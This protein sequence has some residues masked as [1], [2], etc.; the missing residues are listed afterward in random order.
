MWVKYLPDGQ[1]R[2]NLDYLDEYLW[3]DD[4]EAFLK[5][6]IYKAIRAD[7]DVFFAHHNDTTRTWYEPSLD[8]WRSKGDRVMIPAKLV[9]NP[10]R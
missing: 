5:K 7:W 8:K 10:L 2:L 6:Y 3:F 9:A 4:S 1:I